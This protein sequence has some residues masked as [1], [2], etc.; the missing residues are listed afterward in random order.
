MK[1]PTSPAS[2]RLGRCL[3]IVGA[4]LLVVLLPLF[5]VG[6]TYAQT[7]YKV[8]YGF[9]NNPDGHRP[10]SGVIQDNGGN[11]Y[12]TTQA[13]G[14]ADY[15]VVFKLTPNADGTWTESI[16]H[17]FGG[18]DGSYPGGNLIFDSTGRLYGT[19]RAGGVFDKGTVDRLV[20][21]VDGSW[22]ESVLYSFTGGVDGGAPYSTLVFDGSGALYGTTPGGGNLSCSFT[23]SSGGCG[24]VFKVT[25]NQD[26]SWTESVLHAFQGPDGAGGDAG[27]TF[28]AA[29][30]LYGTA[31]VGGDPTCGCGV[32]FVLKPNADGTWSETVIHTFSGPDGAQPTAILILDGAGNLYGSTWYGG[33]LGCGNTPGC[34]LVFRLKPN[35][36]GSWTEGILHVFTLTDGA[37][38]NSAL[39]FDEAGNLYGVAAGG[40]DPTCFYNGCGLVFKLSP[41]P[42]GDWGENPLHIFSGGTDGAFPSGS[43]IFDAA[44]H[45]Y[46]TADQAVNLNGCSNN[47]CGGVFR[48][49]R[50]AADLQLQASASPNPVRSHTSYIYTFNITNNGPDP[51][52]WP[53]LVAHVPYGA[54][55]S[56]YAIFSAP[57][58]CVTPAVNTRGEVTCHYRGT[59]P[60]GSTWT[61]TLTVW[62]WAPSGTVITQTAAAMA[63][64]HD[65]KW[66][67]NAVTINTNVQ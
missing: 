23:G 59:Q 16:L 29:G 42:D 60:V 10:A 3:R 24:V 30:N 4:A 66:S 37:Y 47:Q 62:A 57:G 39:V 7:A 25:P 45:L 49:A 28:D 22:T 41:N 55:F 17:S 46:G 48:L 52:E 32:V 27:L 8:L 67:N 65:P 50:G 15:G 6:S 35:P 51:S 33:K 2:G 9:Q 54:V 38:P 36:D 19:T 61:V 26:G 13:G 11:F 5:L 53:R 31:T 64:T 20:P 44:G 14:S 18:E 56:S 34:G 1:S 63:A 12:G 40:G 58:Y 43:L 21:N